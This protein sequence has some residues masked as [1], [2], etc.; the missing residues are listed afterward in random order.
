[1]DLDA[2]IQEHHKREAK[3]HYKG[4]RGY[5]PSV[6]YWV[7]ADQILGHEYPDGNVPAGMSNLPLIQLGFS[8]VSPGVT[9]LYFR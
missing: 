4:G 1:M 3:C 8:R 2:T 5:Q 6:I 7:E 9:K